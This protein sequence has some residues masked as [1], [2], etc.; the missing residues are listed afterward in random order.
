MISP[1]QAIFI[2]GNDWEVLIWIQRLNIVKVEQCI[3]KLQKY[4]TNY[5]SEKTKNVVETELEAISK[6]MLKFNL[7]ELENFS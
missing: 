2:T 5:S 7:Y 1:Q 6:Q 4:L 3:L